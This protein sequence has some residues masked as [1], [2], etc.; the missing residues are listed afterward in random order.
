[1]KNYLISKEPILDFIF[2]AVEEKE[3]LPATKN[4]IFP[5][6]SP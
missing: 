3:D 4:P 2:K 1:M 5:L 6:S